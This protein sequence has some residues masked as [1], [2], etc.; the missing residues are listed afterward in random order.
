ME[1]Y[2]KAL[3]IIIIFTL[4]VSYLN[5]NASRIWLQQNWNNR[6]VKC[7]PT[8]IWRAGQVKDPNGEPY[9]ITD[10]FKECVRGEEA[11]SPSMNQL[12]SS[13]KDVMKGTSGTFDMFSSFVS[14][15]KE[16]NAGFSNTVDNMKGSASK[17][18]AYFASALENLKNI[19]SQIGA[20]FT[21]ISYAGVSMGNSMVA[22]AEGIID[23]IPGA[24]C[25]KGNTLIKLQNGN[26]KYLKDMKPDEVMEDGTVFKE[27]IKVKGTSDNPFFKIYSQSLQKNIYVT[28]GHLLKDPNTGTLI[29][30]RAYDKAVPTT[31]YD[32]VI[33]CFIT[34]TNLMKIGEFTFGD[35]KNQRR[36]L[37]DITTTCF[38]G[39]TPVN[40]EHGQTM[41]ICDI[42]H[43][44]ILENGKK[45]IATL[46]I[47]GDEDNPFYKLYSKQLDKYVFVTGTH[48]IFDNDRDCFLPVSESNIAP[49]PIKTNEWSDTMYCL[50]TENHHIGVGEL[51]F[52]DW[53]D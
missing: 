34:D 20:T 19:F 9:T 35:C 7:N 27:L 51:I 30:V 48:L 3:A 47:K 22:G 49:G 10:T 24:S 6:D 25:L 29:N 45:V 43:G 37:E 15:M 53:E 33:Y 42:E 5:Y 1:E 8:Y 40:M 28:G 46:K 44:M 31:D 23:K 52:W 4:M 14:A 36:D 50:V 17:I 26:I 2:I 41:S 12:R 38:R 32:D 18:V 13:L 39:D 21:A 11:N 16:N